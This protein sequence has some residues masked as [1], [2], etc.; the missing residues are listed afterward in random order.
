MIWGL[1]VRFRSALC[2]ATSIAANSSLLRNRSLLFSGYLCV[3]GMQHGA[4]DDAAA[5]YPTHYKHAETGVLLE[6]E[7]PQIWVYAEEENT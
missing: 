2:I 6:V 7:N 4:G 1:S 5:V 3:E